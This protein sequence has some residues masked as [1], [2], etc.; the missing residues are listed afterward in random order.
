MVAYD[1]WAGAL[2]LVL[3]VRLVW[4]GAKTCP[5]RFC[6]TFWWHHRIRFER[7]SHLTGSKTMLPSKAGRLRKSAA[8]KPIKYDPA[9]REH[10]SDLHIY[11]CGGASGSTVF[12]RTT[13]HPRTLTDRPP[14]SEV[15][16]FH[17][18]SFDNSFR[19]KVGSFLGG[20]WK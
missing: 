19:S 1:T 6:G 8:I 15:V 4:R 2:A 9:I 14:R 17:L 16:K 20:H 11:I 18:L 10:R 3:W 7:E 13:P 5:F 12:L